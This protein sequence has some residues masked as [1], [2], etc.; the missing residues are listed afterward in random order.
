M[1]IT[2]RM[3]QCQYDQ[4]WAD[5]DAVAAKDVFCICGR[6]VA[7]DHEYLLVHKVVDNKKTTFN[8]AITEAKKFNGAIISA[9]RSTR[10]NGSFAIVVHNSLGGN[11][12]YASVV[13]PSKGLISGR[14]YMGSDSWNDITSISII[15]DEIIFYRSDDKRCELQYFAQRHIQAF[16]EKTTR[17]VQSLSIGVVG[18]SGTGSIV[19]EQLARLGTGKLVLVDHD[20]VE[21]KNLNRILNSKVTDIGK[22]KT[23]VLAEAVEGIGLG[24]KVL[25]LSMDLENQLAIRA[26][27]EC[28]VVFG[29]MDGVTGR[30]LLNRIAAF[31]LIP[32]F[33][34]GVRLDADGRGGID[35]ICGRIN[36]LIPGGSSLLSRGCITT[37]ALDAESLMKSNPE[38]YANRLKEG[39]IKGVE[40]ERPAVITP[41]MFYSALVVNEFLARIHPYR[42]DENSKFRS[43]SFSLAQNQFYDLLFDDNSCPSLAKYAGRGDMTPL[44]NILQPIGAKLSC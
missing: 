5:L 20:K 16:G 9:S 14:Y 26:I 39:Y 4:I 12:A 25:S 29:C 35:N 33:D 2:L 3:T 32:Y 7:K 37:D 36:Y 44:L 42:H 43:H 34:V 10:E 15:G 30:H 41:N 24:T 13:I 23:D 8:E 31:Y 1:E 40:V 6:H 19:V 38:E 17:L 27:S 11:I 22:Y 28:D 18:C 21:E